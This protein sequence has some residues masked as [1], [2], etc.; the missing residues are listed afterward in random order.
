MSEITCLRINIGNDLPSY[1]CRKLF[2]FVLYCGEDGIVFQQLAAVQAFQLHHD[3]DAGD[4]G[5]EFF[6]E[7][8]HR[9]DRAAGREEIVH[10]QHPLSG[11]ERIFVD[12]EDGAAV[13]KVIFDRHGLAGELALLAD[14]NERFAEIVGHRG[15]ED[16]SSGLRADDQ[17]P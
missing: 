14:Q 11:F 2:A 10:D 8:S 13:L 1:W 9:L 3:D 4:C 12:L 6:H 17:Y 15:A 5:T 16:E 7:L